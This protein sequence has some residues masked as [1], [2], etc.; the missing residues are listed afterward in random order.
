MTITTTHDEHMAIA[1]RYE[2][3]GRWSQAAESYGAAIATFRHPTDSA[4][5]PDVTRLEDLRRVAIMRS[6][7]MVSTPATNI[8]EEAKKALDDQGAALAAKPSYHVID[9]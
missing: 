6:H 8:S 9:G 4:I 3:E 7:E 2:A 5:A 1:S